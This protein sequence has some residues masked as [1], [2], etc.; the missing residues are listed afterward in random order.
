VRAYFGLRLFM[1]HPREEY[2]DL[3]EGAL[4]QLEQ[5][6]RTPGITYGLDRI[7]GRRYHIDEFAL[8]MRWRLANRARAIAEDERILATEDERILRSTQGGPAPAR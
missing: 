7:T 2:R 4:A 1:D 3:V 5:Y 8:E 6:E